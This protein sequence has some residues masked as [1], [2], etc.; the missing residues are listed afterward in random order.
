MIPRFA[1]RE[2]QIRKVLDDNREQNGI[3]VDLEAIAE[4]PYILSEQYQGDNPDDFIP[5]GP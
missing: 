4:N 1:L 5:G 3:N 2:D